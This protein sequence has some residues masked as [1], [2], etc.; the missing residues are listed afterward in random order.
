MRKLMAV[1]GISSVIATG[2]DSIDRRYQPVRHPWEA[3]QLLWFNAEGTPIR[4]PRG[5]PR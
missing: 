1:A 3:C 2:R 4:R 5:H